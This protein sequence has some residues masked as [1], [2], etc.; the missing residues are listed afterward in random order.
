M[1]VHFIVISIEQTKSVQVICRFAVSMFRK[2]RLKCKVTRKYSHSKMRL[3][4][5]DRRLSGI[6]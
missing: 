6:R 5:R 3:T 1:T 2:A 4:A